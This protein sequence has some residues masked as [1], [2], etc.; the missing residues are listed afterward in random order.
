MAAILQG[1][2]AIALATAVASACGTFSLR[3]FDAFLDDNSVF[4][5]AASKKG[6]GLAYTVRDRIFLVVE[7]VATGIVGLVE[8]GLWVAQ[9][10]RVE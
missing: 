7:R 2:F 4:C 10:R 8:R 5:V 3:G 6:G 9:R 1:R